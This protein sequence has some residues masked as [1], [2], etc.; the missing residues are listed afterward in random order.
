[1]SKV[2]NINYNPSHTYETAEEFGEIIHMTT[3]YIPEHKLSNIYQSFVNY[4]K[5]ADK[6]DYIL[7]SGSNLV[8]I[9]A[10]AAWLTEHDSV[11]VLQFSRKKDENGYKDTYYSYHVST[12]GYERQA[13]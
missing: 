4:A 2:Y 6:T 12:N 9:L 1:M 10:V 3:G 8:C 13:S 11:N 5:R 7:L